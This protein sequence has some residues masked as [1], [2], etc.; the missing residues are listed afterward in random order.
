MSDT[1]RTTCCSH[2]LPPL[3]RIFTESTFLGFTTTMDR[4]VALFFIE[5]GLFLAKAI[6]AEVIED[7][8]E[9]VQLQIKR[10]D[11][12][13]DKHIEGV[14]DE[15]TS[16]AALQAMDAENAG[17]MDGRVRSGTDADADDALRR[18]GAVQNFSEREGD[19]AEAGSPIE[20]AALRA[21]IQRSWVRQMLY[22][23]KVS[24]NEAEMVS[25]L[26]VWG[27]FGP[28]H[29]DLTALEREAR[30]AGE[31]VP[32]GFTG[33]GADGVGERGD[34]PEEESQEA[35]SGGAAVLSSGK[36]STPPS[37]RARL[38]GQ[39]EAKAAGRGYGA[40]ATRPPVAPSSRRGSGDPNPLVPR[41][42]QSGNHGSS[43][44]IGGGGFF[45]TAAF[46]DR[47]DSDSD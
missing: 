9:P 45:A 35:K 36:P 33:A 7:V 40:T 2:A 11:Y 23:W 12:L 21:A 15:V 6:I 47:A 17:V 39:G 5:H 18:A 22:G 4:V 41:G 13:V 24:N 27:A 16:V 28:E 37:E 31:F 29:Q 8:T 1:H 20:Q 46:A 34:I 19:E 26:P 38:S 44:A 30:E 10:Q 43:A 32:Q 14:E 42:V 3:R 25:S